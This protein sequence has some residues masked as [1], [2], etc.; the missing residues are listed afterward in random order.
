[1]SFLDTKEKRKSFAISAGIMAALLLFFVFVTVFTVLDPPEESGIAVNFGNTDVGSGP[2]EP[3]RPTKVNPEKSPSESTQEASSAENI[4]TSEDVDD[5]PVIE[6]QPTPQENK[7]TKKPVDKPVKK[8][9]PKPDT[10]VLDALNNV[11]GSKPASGENNSGE[12]PGDGPGNKG[13][14]NGDPYANT[15][16]GNPGNGQGG[17]GYGLSGRGKVGGRGIEPDCIETGTVIVQIEV[18]RSGSVVKATPGVKGT[19]NRAACLL[20]AARKSAMTYKFSAA[21]E[22]RDIQIGFI[23]IIFKV[24]E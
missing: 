24:G 12:G 17:K 6:S 1:M 21:A 20:D 4:I 18:N 22:A 19:T 14:I 15:Y 5:K 8:P 3:A 2:I 9:E 16:Y 11:T 10:S 23:E 13:D 7:P